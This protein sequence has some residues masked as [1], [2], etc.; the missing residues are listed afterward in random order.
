M[1]DS[2]KKK[3]IREWQT[4][5][6]SGRD[7][8]II[9]SLQQLREEGSKELIKD[10]A[11]VFL[12]NPGEELA[13][14][15]CAF[16]NDLKEQDCAKPHVEFLIENSSFPYRRELIASCWQNALNYSAYLSFFT[17]I[18]FKS[19]YE[20]AIEAFSVI[21]EDID[22]LPAPERLELSKKIESGLKNA[23]NEKKALLQELLSVVSAVSGP[24]SMDSEE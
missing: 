1:S 20:T 12:M 24:F 14:Q 11:A 10:I 16:F 9:D 18:V 5:L 23:E 21:E 13:M 22:Q 7:D 4:R 3:G 17:D 8:V 15:L 19:D 2:Q 6:R